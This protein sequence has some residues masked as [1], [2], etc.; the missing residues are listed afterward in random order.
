MN[1]L[2][3]L[4]LKK[5]IDESECVNNT[6]NIRALKHSVLIR[7]DIRKLD[8]LKVTK[9]DV[10]LSDPPKY[11]ELCQKEAS[12]LFT[13]YTDIFNKMVREE[14]DLK[15][16]TNI[17]GVLKMIEDE[18]VDQHEGSVMVGQLL[19]ELYVDSALRRGEN[20]DKEHEAEKVKPIEGKAVSW[21]AYKMLQG[22]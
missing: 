6:D 1:S 17:L 16:M 4:N 14:L 20:L 3:R 22:T 15:I 13:N 7:D 11:M 8:R 12:F 19:K 2:D 9:L 21:R 5:M 10:K 18:K